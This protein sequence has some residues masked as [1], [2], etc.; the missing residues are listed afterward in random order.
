MISTDSSATNTNNK[1]DLSSTDNAQQ[2]V[3]NTTTVAQSTTDTAVKSLKQEQQPISDET[4]AAGSTL[5]TPI[6]T[7]KPDSEHAIKIKKQ[8][9]K[10]SKN[11]QSSSASISDD[12]TKNGVVQQSA[13]ATSNTVA[14]TK[15]TTNP[16]SQV[17]KVCQNFVKVNFLSLIIFVLNKKECN[18]RFRRSSFAS[19]YSAFTPH[20]SS[21]QYCHITSP[22]P[23]DTA[24][25]TR[26][27]ELLFIHTASWPIGHCSS[28]FNSIFY[29]CPSRSNWSLATNGRCNGYDGPSY[30]SCLYEWC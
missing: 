2:T 28:G 27:H 7:T 3:T 16:Y 11:Q 26:L 19:S 17:V 1:S 6:T 12:Q 15:K 5:T 22:S 10:Q 24:A 25:T 21:S 4:A 13:T 9:N 20:E 8:T 14:A 29:S 18:K 30:S 23:P